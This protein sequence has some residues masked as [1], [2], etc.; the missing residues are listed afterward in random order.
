MSTEKYF[1]TRLVF[2]QDKV[3]IQRLDQLSECVL[4]GEWPIVS[5]AAE[6]LLQNQLAANSPMSAGVGDVDMASLP[7][8]FAVGEDG[9]PEDPSKAF[10]LKRVSSY[11]LQ[12]ICPRIVTQDMNLFTPEAKILIPLNF[13]LSVLRTSFGT[14][15]YCGPYGTFQQ[16][17]IVNLNE[18]THAANECLH[19][20]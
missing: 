19:P 2:R 6:A 12:V 7:P 18:N 4:K 8:G 10:K 1:Q 14:L 16:L 13:M 9:Q 11:D 15:I 5:K 17:I 20:D 3:V